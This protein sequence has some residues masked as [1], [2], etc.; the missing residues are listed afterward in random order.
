MSRKGVIHQYK[1][2]DENRVKGFIH[3]TSRKQ[4]YV[5]IRYVLHNADLEP[6]AM[7]SHTISILKPG[8]K[9]KIDFIFHEKSKKPLNV[10]MRLGNDYQR[11]PK[12][13]MKTLQ[14]KNHEL[15]ALWNRINLGW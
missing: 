15:L 9:S 2:L 7:D 13:T 4:R 1:L 5:F 11:Q 10:I 14:G 6:L 8:E 12:I 3:N